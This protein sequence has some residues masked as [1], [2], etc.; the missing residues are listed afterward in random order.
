M[1]VVAEFSL[2]LESVLLG[3]VLDGAESTRLDVDRV[4]P[5]GDSVAYVWVD[6]PDRDAVVGHLRETDAVSAVTPLDE[7]PDRTLV[8]FEWH[9]EDDPVFDAVAAVDGVVLDATAERDG[10]SV[11]IRF[12][13]KTDVQTF[14]ERLLDEDVPVQVAFPTETSSDGGSEGLSPTQRETILVALRS[15]YFEVPRRVSLA[16]LADEL[17]VSDQAVSERLRRGLETLLATT[18]TAPTEPD[19]TDRE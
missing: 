19:E 13:H 1:T 17:G 2:P 10:W 11:R 12:P 7:L 18:L 4:A 8:R 3:R 16:E 9:V 6:G 15:G 14:Y 5:V